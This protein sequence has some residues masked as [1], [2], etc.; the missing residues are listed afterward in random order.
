MLLAWEWEH[1]LQDVHHLMVLSY[2]LQHPSRYSA[3]AVP[4]IINMLVDFVESGVTPQAMRERLRP[5]VD[6]GKRD[7]KI[8]GT[9]DSYGTYPSPVT[10]TMTAADV[11]HNGPAHYYASV[12]QWTESILKSLRASGVLGA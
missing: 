5:M 9:P 2:Y 7:Y 12:H 8:T 4:G 3:E 1:N 10:W 11:V 6:S